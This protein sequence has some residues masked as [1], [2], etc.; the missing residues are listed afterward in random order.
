[1]PSDKVNHP[2]HYTYGKIEC[3]EVTEHMGFLEGNIIKYI[4]R[5]KHKHGIE[6]LKKAQWYLN[7][8]IEKETGNE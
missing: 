2:S 3:I 7:R 6:D 5:Y 8:L 4:W 1:M